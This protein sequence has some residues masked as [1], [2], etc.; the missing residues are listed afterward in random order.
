M[1]KALS[2]DI[3][4]MLMFNKTLLNL[5]RSKQ[6]NIIDSICLLMHDYLELTEIMQLLQANTIGVLTTELS[7]KHHIFDTDDSSILKFIS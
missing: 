3:E 7:T 2:G 1:I 4:A 5:H 6:M